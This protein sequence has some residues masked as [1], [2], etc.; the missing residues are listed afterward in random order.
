MRRRRSLAALPLALALVVA[1]CGGTPGEEK[2]NEQREGTPAAQV[3]TSGF[4]DLGPV[5]LKVIS[6]EGSGG[7]Q[8]AL[9][10]LSKSF[11][12][13][14]PNVTVDIS[15]RDFAAWTKQAKLV[16]SSNN[17][18]DVFGGNQ[19]YQLDG[20]LVKAGLILPLTEYA[21]AY[22]WENS[23]S[24]ET[25][26]QFRWTDDGQT[27]GDGTLWAIAQTGQS[28][29]VFADKRKLDAAG[30]DPAALETFDDF[31]AALAKLRESLPADEP[32]I[33]LGN[34]DQYHALHVW[35]GIQGAYVPAQ[36]VRDWIFQRDGATFDTEG[37]LTALEKL[38]EWAE[39]GYFGKPDQYNSVSESDVGVQFAKGK[40]AL[41]IA[42][43]WQAATVREG[44]GENG[45]F[46]NIPPGESGN[47]TNIGAT[48]FPMHISAKTKNPDLAAAYLDWIAGPDAAKEL[49]AT[50]QIPAATDA[51]AEMG[52]PLGQQV[53]D[54]WDELVEGGGLTLFHDWSSPTMLQTIGQSFQEMLAGRI[55][56]QDV[57]DRVQSDW[58]EY[59]QELAGG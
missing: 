38:Q 16:A 18:P 40:G 45:V 51:T 7:P 54:G 30:V 58:E 27:F 4:E 1:A 39:K 8:D 19:G 14:Y 22:G 28:V 25:L 41:L 36:E 5:T 12:E 43:N 49:V 56:P 23:F 46:F 55:S 57:V 32:V 20:E 44:L 26:Q 9:R 13:K 11:E 17:P 42:G 33:A 34:K 6:P 10:A 29:G 50:Q 53:K 31:D 35:G 37:N 52:D 3:K 48:S 21:K 2:P 47:P 15:F 24:P 59:H